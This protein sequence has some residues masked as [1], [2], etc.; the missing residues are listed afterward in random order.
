[1]F[2]SGDHGKHACAGGIPHDESA[3][4]SA[5]EP[6]I[7]SDEQAFAGPYLLDVHNVRG[8]RVYAQDTFNKFAHLLNR[9]SSLE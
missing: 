3:D 7:Y 8:I 1:M 4:R 5:G 2:E 9:G 6:F